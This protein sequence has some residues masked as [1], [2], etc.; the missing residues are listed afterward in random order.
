MADEDGTDY[1]ELL[2]RREEQAERDHREVMKEREAAQSA[3]VDQGAKRGCLIVAAAVVAIGIWIGVSASG[4]DDGSTSTAGGSERASADEQKFAAFSVCKDFVKDRLKAPATA[5]FP[6]FFDRDDEVTVTGFGDGPYTVR[7]HVDAE[8]G[9][10]A[11]LSTS[12]SCTVTNTG[13]G[14]WR[15]DDIALAE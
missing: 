15:L 5:K 6:D 12:F 2:R 13:G 1:G 9:F 14:N 7:S 8:N 4:D 10:G 11:L 3:A